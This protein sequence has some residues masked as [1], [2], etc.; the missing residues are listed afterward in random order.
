VDQA[1]RH[2]LQHL[3]ANR[4]TMQIVDQLE[5]VEVDI[6]GCHRTAGGTGQRHRLIDT[7]AEMA[8]IG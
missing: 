3:I 5:T 2:D 4:A 7:I 8:A 1:P 6:Y